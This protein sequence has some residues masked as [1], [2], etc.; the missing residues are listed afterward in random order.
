MQFNNTNWH[1]YRTF[2]V[3]YE[4][5]NLQRAADVFIVSRSAISQSIKDLGNQLGVTLFTPHPKGV[6]PTGDADSLY[7]IIKN[8]VSA[9]VDAENSLQTLNADSVGNIKL[10]TSTTH[11]IL[12]LKDYMKQFCALYP[13]IT[14]EIISLET[15]N[16]N[17]S[18]DVDFVLDVGSF[19]ESKDYKTTTLFNANIVLVACKDFLAK[20]GLAQSITIEQLK[21]LPIISPNTDDF[22]LQIKSHI[23]TTSL[24]MSHQLI[25]GGLGVG[26][27]AQELLDKLN[28]NELVSLNV[29]DLRLPTSS[30][31]CG[32]NKALSKQSRAFIDGLIKFCKN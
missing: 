18:Y 6:I 26:Y 10:A 5:R 25:K 14:F 8:A 4:T 23:K 7:P 30:V 19:F 27:L 20:R 11:I 29:K 31:I 2:I 24:E 17:T 13:K 12:Y 28:D 3:V 16:L 9:I 32:Y 15:A 22:G 21:T 1:L